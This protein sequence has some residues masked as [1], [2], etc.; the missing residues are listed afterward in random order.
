M[1][2]NLFFIVDKIEILQK[3]CIFVGQKKKSQK[4]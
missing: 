2:G 1:L 3:I 4:N